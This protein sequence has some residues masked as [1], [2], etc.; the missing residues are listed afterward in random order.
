MHTR[1]TADY[2]PLRGPIMDDNG[3][4][5]SG[6]SKKERQ[7]Y[8]QAVNARRDM[9]KL[10]ENRVIKEKRKPRK[11]WKQRMVEKARNFKEK[12]VA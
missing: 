12:D 5:V 3:R 8:E 10:F 2:S 6:R 4:D 9:M 1:T 7:E 11:T